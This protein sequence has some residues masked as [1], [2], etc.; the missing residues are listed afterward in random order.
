MQA[1]LLCKHLIMISK[2]LK[3]INIIYQFYKNIINSYF[4]KLI[5]VL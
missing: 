5:F 4:V 2:H 3:Y 1:V